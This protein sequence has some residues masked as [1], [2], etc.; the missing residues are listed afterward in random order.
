MKIC[1]IGFDNLPMLAPEFEQYHL[2]GESVQQT[3]LARALARR[4]HDVSMIVTDYGQPDPA[5]WHGIRVFK[6]YRRDAGM[7]MIR[8]FH[9]R[10]TGMWSALKRA[11]ADI[12]YTSCADMLP[13]MLALFC[14]RFDRRF[15]FRAASD[16]DCDRSRLHLLVRYARDRRLYAYGLRRAH[17]ILVQSN[18][19]ADLLARS[20]GLTSRVAGMLVDKPLPNAADADIDVLWV[21]NIKRVK[22]PDRLLELAA[23]LPHLKF[24][25]V[26]GKTAYEEKLFDDFTPAVAALSNVVFHGRLSYRKT[27]SLYDR[28]RL[29]INTSDVEGFP[30]VYLQAWVRGVP[31]VTLLDPD[32]IIERKGLG[33]AAGSFAEMADAIGTLL[34]N[35]SRWQSASERCRAF[36][37][38]EYAE[39][40]VLSIYLRTFEDV[41][42]NDHL[43][44]GRFAASEYHV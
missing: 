28:T 11:D 15:V 31:V 32:G 20:Y 34:E 19:Q 44:R 27:A 5:M 12:Y 2:G 22:R 39:D 36:M 8:F 38:R 24:H 16:P 9:P 14:R 17:A 37:A 13:G 1:F 6:A 21:G 40:K 7:K 29:L 4:G 33:A 42:R 26:G 10:W 23:K 41:M 18:A 35:P 25:V 43:G 30:N 3:L